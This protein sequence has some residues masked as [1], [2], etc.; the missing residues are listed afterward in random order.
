[1]KK[2]NTQ[3]I[4][5]WNVRGINGKEEVLINELEETNLHILTLTQKKGSGYKEMSGG[6]MMIYNGIDEMNTPRWNSQ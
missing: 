3:K 6:H 2:K 1:M 4:G 5:T